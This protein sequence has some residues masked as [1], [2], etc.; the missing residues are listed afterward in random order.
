MSWAK[1]SRNV[2]TSKGISLASVTSNGTSQRMISDKVREINCKVVHFVRV[3][4]CTGV[5]VVGD[6]LRIVSISLYQAC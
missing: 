1:H 2:D 5:E 3:V 6:P 4:G